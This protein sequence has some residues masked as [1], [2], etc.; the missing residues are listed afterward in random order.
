MS[1]AEE[2]AYTIRES[3]AARQD[4]LLGLAITEEGVFARR[5]V[6]S[7]SMVAVFGVAATADGVVAGG[8]VATADGVAYEIGATDGEDA[9][10]EA[11]VITEDGAVIVDAAA[12]ADDV[13]DASADDD[14]SAD[15][16]TSV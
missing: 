5:V 4:I 14:A 9:V 3:L 1:T 6:S 16:S 10:M 7:P 13:V 8:A 2:I 11:G 15:E 12:V